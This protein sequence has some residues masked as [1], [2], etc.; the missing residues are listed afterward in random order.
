MMIKEKPRIAYLFQETVLFLGM[1]F[2]LILNSS[3]N[4]FINAD[5]QKGLALGITLAVVVWIAVGQCASQPVGKALLLWVAIY[6][7]VVFFSLDPRRS[8]SQMVLMSI[9]V[10]LFSLS[11]DL[12]ARGWPRELFIKTLLMVGSVVILFGLLEAGLWY[13][14]WLQSAPGQWIPDVVY[15][16]GNANVIAMF[17]NLMVMLAG[18]RLLVTRGWLGRAALLVLIV[19][20]LWLLFLTSSRGGWLGTAAGLSVLAG[21]ALV[22][23]QLDWR[24]GWLFL[25]ARPALLGVLLVAMLVGAGIVGVFLYQRTL[26]PSHG[27]ISM[28]RTDYWPPAWEAFLRSPLVGNGQFTYSNAFIRHNS[29]PPWPLFIHSHG[30]PFNLLAEM[31]LAGAVGLALLV[32]SILIGLWKHLRVAEGADRGV[33]MGVLAAVAA[34]AVHSLFD[35]F[36]TETI[37]L[38]SLCIVMGAALGRPGSK[39]RLGRLQNAWALLVVVGLWAEL[40]MA[41]PLHNGVRLANSGRWDDAAEVFNQAVERDPASVIAYQQRALGSSVLAERNQPGA[42]Q[43]AV[44]DL[45]QVVQREPG[46]AL[47]HANLGALY[48]AQNRPQEAVRSLEK[49]LQRA[50][51]CGLCALNLGI[52]REASGDPAGSAQAYQQ[53]LQLGQ[54]VQAYFWRSSAPRRLAQSAWVEQHPLLAANA[55]DLAAAMKENPS[56][57][58]PYLQLAALDLKAN[59]LAAAQDLLDRAALAYLDLPETQL[60]RD[61]LVVELLARQGNLAQAVAQGSGVIASYRMMGLYG[62]GS[63]GQLYYAPLMFRRPAMALELTPQLARIELPDAWGQRLAMLIDWAERGGNKALAEQMRAEL[64]L[65]IPDFGQN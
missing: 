35:C 28:A 39:P 4:D 50:P 25:R 46:W 34:S 8:A 61:W 9:S 18:A 41:A 5:L 57:A 64:N 32:G 26:H 15:R 22:T 1:V 48:L 16:P 19:P 21:L 54:P 63:L 49:S 31:G 29:A 59:R 7:V 37:G 56:S 38:W 55:S 51:R 58:G 44:A 3:T 60:E 2:L 45:E 23:G 33:L 65:L 13:A 36:H 11:A 27:P 62:P 42:L 10:L 40:W 52:A 12:A 53:A 20:A 17:L 47:N 6:L 24:K 30:T 43:Q 14:R